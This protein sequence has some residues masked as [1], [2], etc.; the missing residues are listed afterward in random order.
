MNQTATQ[1]RPL[2]SPL[3]VGMLIIAAVIAIVLA[4]LC[5][6]GAV[7]AEKQWTFFYIA[8]AVSC[9]VFFIAFVAAATV[10]DLLWEI[11]QQLKHSG[12]GATA[13]SAGAQAAK[14]APVRQ[15]PPQP[16]PVTSPSDVAAKQAELDLKLAEIERTVQDPIERQRLKLRAI[17]EFC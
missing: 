6:F 5:L 14:A 1:A 11:L 16:A 2:Q 8:S 9:F 13:L 4:L 17:S 7:S 3:T 10:I 12:S 15:R